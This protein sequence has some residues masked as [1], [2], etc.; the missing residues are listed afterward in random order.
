MQRITSPRRSEV[1]TPLPGTLGESVGP[2]MTSIGIGTECGDGGAPIL[3]DGLPRGV[4]CVDR[5]TLSSGDRITRCK[6]GRGSPNGGDAPCRVPNHSVLE[7][8]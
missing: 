8:A 3:P 1:V 6:K 2:C 7:I 5:L 4:P